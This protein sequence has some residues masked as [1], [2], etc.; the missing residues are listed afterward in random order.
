MLFVE[1]FYGV[2]FFR[3]KPEKPLARRICWY[4]RLIDF[5][6]GENLPYSLCAV[7]IALESLK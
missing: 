6:Y 2:V 7:A 4:V 5:A 1:V 3:R